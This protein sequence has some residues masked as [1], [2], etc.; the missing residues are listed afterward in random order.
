M[1]GT[2][3]AVS[4]SELAISLQI[5]I[6]ATLVSLLIGVPLG[7]VAGYKGGW[8]DDFIS[9]IINVVFAFPFLLF[10]LAVVAGLS[11]SEHDGH[12]CSHWD[13]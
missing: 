5:G 10:V 11:K 9:W 2:S 12:L 13:W 7:A 3:L 4:C 8:V 6:F 1:E